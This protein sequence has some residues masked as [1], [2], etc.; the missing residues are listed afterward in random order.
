MLQMVASGRSVAA[1][2]KWLVAEYQRQ[3]GIVPVRLGRHGISKQ[4][5]L[6]LRVTD[7]EID[8][9]AAFVKLARSKPQRGS[10]RA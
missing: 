7:T 9:V 8:Y 2:P 10:S 1:L 4:I 3:M 6:G 5:F